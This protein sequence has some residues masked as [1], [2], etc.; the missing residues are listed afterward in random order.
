MFEQIA[1]TLHLAYRQSWA[2][3]HAGEALKAAAAGGFSLKRFFAAVLMIVQAFNYVLFEVPMTAD[4]QQ[5]DLSGYELVF[6]DEFSGDTL[7]TVAW[8]YR[9]E[10]SRRGGYFAASQV[11]VHDGTAVITA[12]YLE[13]GAFGPGWYA[14]AIALREKYARGYFEIRCICSEGGGFWSAFWIQA[15][16]PYDHELSAGG[17]GGA[18]LD[19]FEAMASD[20]KLP[21]K[22]NA[23]THTIHCNGS[24]DDP[25]H[26]D[27]RILGDFRANDIYNTYNTY[28]LEWTEDEYIFYINGVETCR[29]SFA[30][31]VSKVPEEVIVSLC[32]PEE[33]TFSQGETAQFTVDY[34][35]IYQK[36]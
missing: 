25:E 14:G 1:D 18:E 21:L 9:G 13:N 23:V 34:V 22:R 11:S 20:E 27:S 31:G 36:P 2:I 12:E 35:K 10:G 5:L 28:G 15:D 17:V 6:C 29:S 24:D 4:G 32:V 3:R 30:S 7:D 26:I 16:H 33:I 8:R 19:I